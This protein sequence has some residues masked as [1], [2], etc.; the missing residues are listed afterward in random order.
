M[1]D[2]LG[3]A[4]YYN[5]IWWLSKNIR[6]SSRIFL[7]N[8]ECQSPTLENSFMWNYYVLY[9][10]KLSHTGVTSV[11][12]CEFLEIYFQEKIIYNSVV[13]LLPTFLKKIVNG[14]YKV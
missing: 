13:D 12:L 2:L 10:F 7:S 14:S 5:D 1:P 9:A 11:A 8:L 6:E 4:F 3:L